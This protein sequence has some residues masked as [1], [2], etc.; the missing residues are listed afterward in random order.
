MIHNLTPQDSDDS[1]CSHSH[2]HS[3]TRPRQPHSHPSLRHMPSHL[4]ELE[5]LSP[6]RT[7]TDSQDPTRTSSTSDD[8][9]TT[10]WT[11]PMNDPSPSSYRREPQPRSS[12]S[13]AL[14]TLIGLLLHS[15]SDGI[16]LGAST[17]SSS[18]SSHS[19]SHPDSSNPSSL[20]TVIFL[21]IMLHKAPTA[22]AL[23]SLLTS[24][25]PPSSRSFIR[26]GLVLF[27]LS[28]PLG[29]IFTYLI[30]KLV[31]SG[32]EGAGGEALEWYTG[33]ALVFSGG[34][35]L[36]V[37]THAVTD[38][39]DRNDEDDGTSGKSGGEGIGEAG[40]REKVGK[41][42]KVALVL[43]GMVTPGILSRLVGHGH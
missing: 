43:V 34:T 20:S 29:A 6:P 2:S 36:F 8:P 13:S 39:H 10:D 15:L 31:G 42:L 5:P 27:S 14:S 35:F 11:I 23:S 7:S 24:S 18:S 12:S 32:G 26:R 4:S 22:F 28:A 41:R 16:S 30:L 40:R 21:A 19:H 38:E 25:T 9:T 37:A 3:R 17:L 1:H 33:I